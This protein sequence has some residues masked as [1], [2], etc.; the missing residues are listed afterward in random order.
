MSYQVSAI[1]IARGRNTSQQ[2]EFAPFRAGNRP[3]PAEKDIAF[4]LDACDGNQNLVAPLVLGC[5]L[6][7]LPAYCTICRRWGFLDRGRVKILP[8]SQGESTQW[9]STLHEQTIPNPW[10]LWVILCTFC[11]TIAVV[12]ISFAGGMKRCTLGRHRQG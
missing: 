11:H 6:R 7:R 4:W 1:L 3:L 10:F 12:H 2:G 5:S 8:M 9:G